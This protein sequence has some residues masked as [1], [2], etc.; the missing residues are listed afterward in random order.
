MW[1]SYQFDWP[2]PVLGLNFSWAEPY[3]NQGRPTLF[4]P[5]ELTQ[6]DA[7]LNSSRT[8]FKRGKMLIL[9]ELLIYALGS[10]HGKVA[11]PKSLHSRNSGRLS[12]SKLKK[13]FLID[14][15]AEPFM[16][17]IQCIRLGSWKDRCLNRALGFYMWG[18]YLFLCNCHCFLIAHHHDHKKAAKKVL[19]QC[20]K[21]FNTITKF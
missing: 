18:N 19:K 6:I 1:S 17:L 7:H 15:V 11:V 8:K 13:A 5:P 10:V 3:S 4:R 9:V 21:S 16:C 2:I 12:R 14:S 20:G